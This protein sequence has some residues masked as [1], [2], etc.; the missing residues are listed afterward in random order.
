MVSRPSPFG[1]NDVYM[2]STSNES[3]ETGLSGEI[4]KNVNVG[5]TWVC[6]KMNTSAR[7][8][9]QIIETKEFCVY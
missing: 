8:T 5:K 1:R 3:A 9:N 4:N 6:A 7:I 2:R